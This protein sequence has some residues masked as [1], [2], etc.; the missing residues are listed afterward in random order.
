MN[1]KGLIVTATA[2]LAISS[3]DLYDDTLDAELGSGLVAHYQFDGN[4]VDL[5]GHGYSG[6]V[7]GADP[8]EDRFGKAKS[9]YRFTGFGTYIR[10]GNILENVFCAPVAKFSVTGWAY[11][12]RMG[13][14]SGGGGLMIGKAAGGTYGPY[15]WCISHVDGQIYAQVFFD[16]TENNYLTLTNSVGTNQWFH[17]ALV[18]DGSEGANSRLRLYVD[19]QNFNV[20]ALKV[21]GTIGRT[22]RH[23]EQEVT[24][25]AGHRANVPQI[26]NNLYDGDLDDLRIYNRPLSQPEAQALYFLRE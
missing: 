9:A 10:F 3:C 8:A 26:P 19:G 1:F 21:V 12:R 4:A 13:S 23:S 15:Q 2:M 17:F 6:T 20:S 18:F 24:M 22:T 25:G 11:T 14:R 5:S 7:I 16:T